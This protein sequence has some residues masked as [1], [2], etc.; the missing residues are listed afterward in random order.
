[1]GRLEHN[2]SFSFFL[3]QNFKQFTCLHRGLGRK[4]APR[5]GLLLS[6]IEKEV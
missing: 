5:M 6:K 3:V 4:S 1:M 2:T